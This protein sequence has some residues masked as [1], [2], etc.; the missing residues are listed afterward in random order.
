MASCSKSGCGD[1]KMYHM[2]THRAKMKGYQ[3]DLPGQLFASQQHDLGVGLLLVQ[4]A[5]TH[6]VR[7][8]YVSFLMSTL[9]S[10]VGDKST[11]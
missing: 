11:Q 9:L 5:F 10:Y 2:Q 3:G 8:T 1:P 6:I 4:R 7:S